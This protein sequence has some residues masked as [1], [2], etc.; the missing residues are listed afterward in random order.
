MTKRVLITGIN[1]FTGKYLYEEFLA[2]GYD[3]WGTGRVDSTDPQIGKIDIL[4]LE[5]LTQFIKK[6]NP[7]IVIHLAAISYA[8]SQ[9]LKKLYETNIIGTRNL[10]LSLDSV[11]SA[12]D[13]VVIPS[14]GT[15]YG[16]S[17]LPLNENSRLNPSN[18]YGISKL[19]VEY[20]AKIWSEKLNIIITRP[21]NYTGTGQSD[22]FFIPKIVKHHVTKAK[23]IQLGNIDIY[24]DISDVRTVV[25]TYRRLIEACPVGGI[26]NICSGK[27]ILLKDI[28]NLVSLHTNHKVEVKINSKFQRKDEAIVRVG[29]KSKIELLIGEIQSYSIEQTLNSLISS[30]KN[31]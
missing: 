19:S 23:S 22:M 14:S 29:D 31:Q 30:Y 5:N 11:L 15:V 20:L 8:A 1:S 26:Y 17:E 7:D 24:R 25:A 3:V 10:L 6:V 4:D 21:F 12:P 2:H 18:D 28:F 16:S 9:D 27:A 13:I